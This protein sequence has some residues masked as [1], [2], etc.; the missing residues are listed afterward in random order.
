MKSPKLDL[1]KTTETSLDRTDDGERLPQRRTAQQKRIHKPH[2]CAEEFKR[3]D[4]R[5][6]DRKQEEMH[7]KVPHQKI[8]RDDR[9]LRV[10]GSLTATHVRTSRKS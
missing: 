5:A 1:G 8:R 3:I 6:D 4:G 10:L 7:L 9:Q 2:R